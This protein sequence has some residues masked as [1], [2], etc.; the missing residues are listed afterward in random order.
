MTAAASGDTELAPVPGTEVRIAVRNDHKHR[1]LQAAMKTR[2]LSLLHLARGR[3]ACAGMTLVETLVSISIAVLT[4]S[5]TMNGYVLITRR[6]EW[7]AHSLAAHSMALQRMEQI[8][9]AKWD[10]AAYPQV[11]RV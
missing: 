2:T 6:A 1:R 11:D 7:S 9:S 4:I 3:D 8:R 5:G 10:T